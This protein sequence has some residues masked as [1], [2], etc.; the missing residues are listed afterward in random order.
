MTIVEKDA[1]PD[2]VRADRC[3]SPQ[4]LRSSEVGQAS[5]AATSGNLATKAAEF[6]FAF[7]LTVGLYVSV[8]VCA[9]FGAVIGAFAVGTSASR[10]W[11]FLAHFVSGVIIAGAAYLVMLRAMPLPSSARAWFIVIC[12]GSLF[13]ALLGIWLLKTLVQAGAAL[14]KKRQSGGS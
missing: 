1:A 12:L 5:I 13:G 3:L 11:G 6:Y 9:V 4:K 2:S 14:S 7:P 10:V 8:A